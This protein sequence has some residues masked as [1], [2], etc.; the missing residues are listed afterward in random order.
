LDSGK[1]IEEL[2]QAVNRAE[3]TI[4]QHTS[5][6]EGHAESPGTPNPK[7]EHSGQNGRLT[8]ARKAVEAVLSERG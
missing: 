1:L 2:F 6:T 4:Q 8:K 7:S 3:Q 5:E